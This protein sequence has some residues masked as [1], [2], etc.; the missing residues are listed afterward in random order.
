VVAVLTRVLVLEREW[1]GPDGTKSAAFARYK[2]QAEKALLAAGFPRVYLFRPAYIY[3]VEPRKEP[4]FNY[5][6][7]RAIYPVVRVLFP[8][9]VIRA[10]DLARVIV[11]VVLRQTQEPRDVVRTMVE[12]RTP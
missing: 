10:D 11:D 5:R 1:R 3:P 4:N 7:I 8:N 2:G 9:Q 12:S 6:L